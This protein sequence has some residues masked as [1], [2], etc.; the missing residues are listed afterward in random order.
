MD[1]PWQ[2]RRPGHAN[3]D[4]YYWRYDSF[5][6]PPDS[7]SNDGGS[8]MDYDYESNVMTDYPSGVLGGSV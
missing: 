1:P 3:D 4:I 5:P 7:P 6:L 8:D 2:L